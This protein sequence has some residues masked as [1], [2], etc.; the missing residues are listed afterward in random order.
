MPVTVLPFR[1]P[2]RSWAAF[3]RLHVQQSLDRLETYLTS[4]AKGDPRMPANLKLVAP[5]DEPIITGAEPRVFNAPT[6]LVWKCLSE[7]QHVAR[8]WGPASIGTLSVKEL[9]FRVGG[10]WRFEHALKRG[11]VVAF[12]GR[13]LEIEP[14]RKLV[15]TFGVEGMFDGQEVVETHLLEERD[16]KT[17]YTQLMRFPDIASR[18]GMIASGMEKG[19]LESMAQLDAL[20]DE[21]QKTPAASPPKLNIVEAPKGQ[22]WFSVVRT[23]DAPR[24][25]IYRC[26]T[27]PEHMTHFWGP[28]GSR[29]TVCDI[30]LRVGGVWRTRWEFPD[31]RGWGY[32]SVYTAI[33]P[34]EALHYRDAP[35]DW[36]GGLDGLPPVELDSTIALTGDDR[37]TTVTV[38]VRCVSEAA[39]DENVRRGFTEMVGVGHDRLAAY[40]KTLGE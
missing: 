10:H 18:D 11:P 32:S 36:S 40:I 16:G 9:D 1:P 37:K 25:L 28:H 33:M 8:W 12:T 7:P 24:K 21:L 5:K 35:Y 15:N 19:A 6:A 38:T 34:D 31:G 27:T 30:D 4:I 26:Y 17:L 20:L 39:R 3:Y 22:P 29:L 23:F 14:M 2:R 13:Y